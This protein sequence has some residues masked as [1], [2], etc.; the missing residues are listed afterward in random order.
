MT[1]IQLR[2]DST[3]AW[4]AANPVLAV[5]E[6]GLDITNDRRKIGDG[7]TPW[8]GLPYDGDPQTRMG[9]Y[10]FGLNGNTSNFA[11]GASITQRDVFSIAQRTGR[12]RLRISQWNQ[13]SGVAPTT[14]ITGV[15]ASIGTPKLTAGGLLDAGKFASAPT[16]ITFNGGSAAAQSIVGAAVLTSDWMD[17]DLDEHETYMTSYGFVAPSAGTLTFSGDSSFTSFNAA[18]YATAEWGG[19]KSDDARFLNA[20]LEYEYA[21]DET[22]RMLV[23]GNSISMGGAL[24]AL[25]F[26]SINAWHTRWA[27]E[28]NGS[29]ASLAVAGSWA[30]HFNPVSTRW[31]LFDTTGFVPDVVVYPALGSSD[32][33]GGSGSDADVQ[34]VIGVLMGCVAIAKAKWPKARHFLTTNPPRS[35]ANAT[36]STALLNAN[37]RIH[38][39]VVHPDISG[40]ID[41]NTMYSDFASPA[42]YKSTSLSVDGVHFTPQGHQ[43]AAQQF[44]SFRK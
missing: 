41:L 2:R 16:L 43:L 35:E 8:N 26:G 29:V 37:A 22:V 15:R 25:N 32:V 14:T 4:A 23:V 39:L 36:F 21:D 42:R 33:L 5:G 9:V 34:A 28:N 40:V 13:L 1:V 38:N 20:W 31:N 11:P 27:L 30:G 17:V 10:A 18:E 24:G 44:P 6:Q 3:A 12:W 7:T 19:G